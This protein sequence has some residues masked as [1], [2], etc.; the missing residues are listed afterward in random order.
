[1][2]DMEREL[3]AERKK[4]DTIAGDMQQYVEAATEEVWR[5]QQAHKEALKI[6]THATKD[7]V[8]AKSAFDQERAAAQD[9]YARETT[10][11][12]QAASAI[13]DERAKTQ[14]MVVE[15]YLAQHVVGQAAHAVRNM[16]VASGGAPVAASASARVMY[17][18][19]GMGGTGGVGGGGGGGGFGGG[20][21]GGGG[22]MMAAG[23]GGPV[24]MSRERAIE[25]ARLAREGPAAAAAM[26]A[27]STAAAARQHGMGG[28]T[29]LADGT[30]VGAD[31]IASAA[32]AAKAFGHDPAA[33]AMAAAAAGMSHRV[34]GVS[35]A[36]HL[37]ADA[38]AAGNH[39]AAFDPTYGGAPLNATGQLAAQR[40]AERGGASSSSD[41]WAD[42]R[43][44]MVRHNTSHQNRLDNQMGILRNQMP[45]GRYMPGGTSMNGGVS[46]AT[47]AMRAE[48]LAMQN[49]VL[50]Q[51]EED[52]K[53]GGAPA[54]SSSSSW[55]PSLW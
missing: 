3:Q 47:E 42:A 41:D 4:V 9:V 20:G 44:G 2:A 6:A 51:Q 48:R 14:E 27:A 31:P 50:T 36:M 37:A 34:D 12:R 10:L 23:R 24:P 5:A 29:G 7:A 40:A 25:Q 52:R 13:A 53:D 46:Q 8:A 32:A 18:D 11:R 26:M 49:R 30:G 45:D 55:F 16:T 21:G 22:G 17:G 43:A 15:R 35:S 38:A 39:A 28:G 54:A 19:A 33:A 1:M